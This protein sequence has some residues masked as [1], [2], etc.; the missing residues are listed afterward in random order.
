MTERVR[1]VLITP[2]HTMLVIRRERPGI[3]PYHVLPGGHVEPSDTSHEAALVREVREEIAGEATNLAHLHTL[4]VRGDTERFYTATITAW[5][6]ADRTGPEFSD[7]DPARGTY[8]LEE[9]PLTHDD[10]SRLNL[11]PDELADILRTALTSGRI[12]QPHT[13]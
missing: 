11:K 6:F 12:P 5:S 7:P 10:V 4:T 1:A 9:I 3:P 2:D 8:Q 13:A